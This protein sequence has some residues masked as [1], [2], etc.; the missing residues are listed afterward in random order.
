[1]AV[2][3]AYELGNAEEREIRSLLQLAAKTKDIK[4]LILVTNEEEKTIEKDG[5]TIDV[6]PL[7]KFLINGIRS[8]KRLYE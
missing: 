1:M 2:Q 5:V 4:R 8:P 6:V 7:Y 3:V